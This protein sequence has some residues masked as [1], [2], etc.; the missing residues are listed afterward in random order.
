MRVFTRDGEGGNHLGIVNDLVDLD[1]GAMQRI[2]AHLG[3]SESV[4][5]DWADAGVPFVRIFTP[6]EEL[7]FAGH[8]LVGGAWC[9]TVIG[10]GGVQRLRYAGGEASISLEGAITWVEVAID[11]TMAPPNGVGSFVSR[12]GI[13]GV[14]SADALLLPKEYVL[15]EL[16]SPEA[17]ASVRPD[18][19]V[20]RERF[21]TLVFARDENRVR[22]RFFAPGSGIPEDPAT[23]SAAVALACLFTER[24]EP[25]G[26]L[27]ISQGEEMGHPSRI[28]LQWGD[29]RAAIG[30]SVVRDEV[31]LL[32]E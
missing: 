27:T 24:G 28:E 30:G 26:R 5:V 25:R 11:A 6:S 32:D 31:R 23:G 14:V 9:L 15:V 18:M 19:T 13:T 8:P 3:F 17:V 10:P 22:C 12:V 4:F 7:S 16:A 29:G 1:D 20:L 21:G 2:A